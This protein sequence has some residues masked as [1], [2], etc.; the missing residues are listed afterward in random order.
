MFVELTIPSSVR[1]S[2]ENC[3]FRKFQILHI[4]PK[5]LLTGGPPKCCFKIPKFISKFLFNR[6]NKN[7]LGTD[8][9]C[10]FLK[11]M[12]RLMHPNIYIYI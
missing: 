8:T 1:K 2:I 11:I 5:F 9:S 10:S 3:L 12:G 6:W 7:R 4:M